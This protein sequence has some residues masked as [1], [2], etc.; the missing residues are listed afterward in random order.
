M[1]ARSQAFLIQDITD[2]LNVIS[3]DGNATLRMWMTDSDNLDTSDTLGIQVLSK[4]GGKGFS[5]Y[6]TGTKTLEQEFE[7]GNLAIH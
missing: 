7:G 6:W 2:P 1:I 5:S 4:D 3:I